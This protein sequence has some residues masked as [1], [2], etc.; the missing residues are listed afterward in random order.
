MHNYKSLQGQLTD[1]P[2]MPDI[3]KGKSYHWA[4]SANAA[5]A[6]INRKLF[7]TTSAANKTNIDN[8]E[9]TLQ[10]QFASETDAAPCNDP[11]PM[12]KK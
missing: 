12:A 6:E 5:L 10:S 7:P 8:L 1:F 2:V 11:L 3:E 4:A 9:N